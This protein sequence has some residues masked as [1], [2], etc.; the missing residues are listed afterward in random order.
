MKEYMTPNIIGILVLCLLIC[1]LLIISKHDIHNHRIP[2]H[3]VLIG[4]LLGLVFNSALPVGWGFNSTIPGGLGFLASLEGIGLGIMALL[5]LYWIRA[6]GAGDVK[7]MGMI[8]AFVGPHDILGVV[9]ATFV[10]GGLMALVVVLL[11]RQ[12]KQLFQNIKL[13]MIGALV[14]LSSGNMPHISDLPISVGKLPYAV[15]ITAG[16]MSYL[17]YQ[18]WF[19]F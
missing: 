10:A 6:M 9:L 16:V 8:G 11:S 2:N 13:I 18:R 14:N 4:I 5:P 1:L 15:A 3:L 17:V 19:K 12:I 7:L